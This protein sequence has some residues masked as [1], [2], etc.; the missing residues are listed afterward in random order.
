MTSFCVS[1]LLIC[2]LCGVGSPQGAR[3]AADGDTKIDD[4]RPGVYLRFERRDKGRIWLRMYNNMKWAVAVRTFTSYLNRRGAITLGNGESVFTLP[5]DEAITSLHYYVEKEP[6]A[7]NKLK[8]PEVFHGDSYSISWIASKGSI[9]FSVPA[10]QLERG[11][12][13]YVPFQYEW[14]L[15][16]QLIFNNEPQH[17]VYFRATD[18]PE[19]TQSRR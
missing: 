8:A 4:V 11:L 15:S 2:A 18:L 13:V 3:A 17:R 5:D 6:A 1:L 7:S 10:G 19:D 12:K 9:L 14:E 16:P